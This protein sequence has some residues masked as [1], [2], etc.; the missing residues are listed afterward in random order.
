MHEGHERAK[1]AR[2][3]L[4]SCGI[5]AGAGF[6]ALD[7]SQV[8]SL[9]AHLDQHRLIKYGPVSRHRQPQGRVRSRARSFHDLLQRRAAF[10]MDTP[11]MG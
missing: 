10:R 11:R 8:D 2:D 3:I 4:K 6:E 7:V 5:N 9:L 1:C